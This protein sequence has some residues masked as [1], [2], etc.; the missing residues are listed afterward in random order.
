MEYEDIGSW[1]IGERD[2]MQGKFTCPTPGHD[3]VEAGWVAS[4]SLR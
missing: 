2:I 1:G 4:I 3:L